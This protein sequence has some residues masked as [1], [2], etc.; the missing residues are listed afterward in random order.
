[1]LKS[2]IRKHELLVWRGTITG[3]EFWHPWWAAVLP[4]LAIQFHVR[5]RSS[6]GAITSTSFQKCI[7]YVQLFFVWRWCVCS[8]KYNML[9]GSKQKQFMLHRLKATRGSFW[10]KEMTL[11]GLQRDITQH[12]GIVQGKCSYTTCSCFHVLLYWFLLLQFSLPSF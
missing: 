8:C 2:K 6:V 10:R 5:F 12:S 9:P 4:A 7:V 3:S 1:M 11:S